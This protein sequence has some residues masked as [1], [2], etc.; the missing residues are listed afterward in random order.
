MK[1]SN[2]LT[3]PI[4]VLALVLTSKLVYARDDSKG[5]AP[6]VVQATKQQ[7]AIA[8]AQMNVT[9]FAAKTSW[10]AACRAPIAAA[11][12]ASADNILRIK[13]AGEMIGDVSDN[14]IMTQVFEYRVTI[15]RLQAAVAACANTPAKVAQLN[16]ATAFNARIA[17]EIGRLDSVGMVMQFK[18]ILVGRT[19]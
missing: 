13:A 15:K 12:A 1:T 7:K 17:A 14:T 11:K 5:P 4:T 18:Q 3:V 8:S 16:A 10:M 9:V 6:A 2:W 19:Y